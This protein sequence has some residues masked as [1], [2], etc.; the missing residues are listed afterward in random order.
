MARLAFLF[1]VLL[2]LF[3]FSHARFITAESDPDVTPDETHTDLPESTTT[4][5][6]PSQIPDSDPPKLLEFKHDD[7]SETDSGVGSVPLTKI[8]FHPVNR[9]FPGRP[10]FPFRHKHNCR[11]H[12]RFHQKRLISYGNDMILSDERSFDPE[13]RGVVP[14]IEARWGG[15]HD[16]HH[17]EH[18]HEH[19]YEDEHDHEDKHRHHRRHHKHHQHGEE[20]EHEGGFMEKF[21][22]FFIHF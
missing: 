18:E 21:R 16:H 4:I 15:F 17:H 12:K 7:A 13:S 22:R 11:F 14:Q 10:L 3:T 9:R 5:F 19:K 20:E 2:L 6:L 1:A 8:R